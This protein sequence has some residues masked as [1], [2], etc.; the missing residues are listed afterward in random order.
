MSTEMKHKIFKQ[1]KNQ[2][3]VLK[4]KKLLLT[5]PKNESLRQPTEILYYVLVILFKKFKLSL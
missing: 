1:K 2:D 4:L 5:K 3:L